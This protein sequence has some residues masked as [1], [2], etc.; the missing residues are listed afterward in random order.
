MGAQLDIVDVEAAPALVQELSSAIEEIEAIDRTFKASA[1]DVLALTQTIQLNTSVS[2]Y[3][4]EVSGDL[5]RVLGELS[6]VRDTLKRAVDAVGGDL[7]DA[8]VNQNML[9]KV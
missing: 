4:K 8:I 1:E 3:L 9:G 6:E 5:G 2:N 7:Y